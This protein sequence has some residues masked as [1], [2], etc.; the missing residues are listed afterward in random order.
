MFSTTSVAIAK[1]THQVPLINQLA[2]SVADVL[3]DYKF[4]TRMIRTA[5]Q[6]SE[7]GHP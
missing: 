6:V 4:L 2:T 5:D 1:V 7:V 3:K